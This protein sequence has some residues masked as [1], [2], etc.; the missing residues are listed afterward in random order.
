MSSPYKEYTDAW[1][2]IL[3]IDAQR[4]NLAKKVVNGRYARARRKR[5]EIALATDTNFLM[6]PARV[7]AARWQRRVI[8]FVRLTQAELAASGAEPLSFRELV[9]RALMLPAVPEE[10]A[11]VRFLNKMGYRGRPGR[12][13]KQ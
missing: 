7:G 9:E 12:P 3:R 1:N 6:P 13:K 2:A 5:D 4:A 10:E 11:V 8:S